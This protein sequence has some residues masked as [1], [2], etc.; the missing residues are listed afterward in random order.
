MN[1]KYTIEKVS[2]QHKII[3]IRYNKPDGSEPYWKNFN[4]E[5][6]SA[7]NQ[8]QIDQMAKA[9]APVVLRAWDYIDTT[10]EVNPADIDI[11]V[12]K[13][14]VYT[15]PPPEPP[16]SMDQQKAAA[17]D[18]VIADRTAREGIGTSN[19]WIDDGSGGKKQILLDTLPADQHKVTMSEAASQGNVGGPAG[20]DLLRVHEYGGDSGNEKVPLYL[21]LTAQRRREVM[22]VLR[23]FNDRCD[24]AEKA[25]MDKIEAGDFSS[26]FDAEFQ[27][28]VEAEIPP[29]PL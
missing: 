15:E 2:R 16:P 12:E 11:G 28:L 10:P 21:E 17:R 18:A 24:R 13:D 8:T 1:Y 22:E 23:D 19:Y 4:P 7:Y 20:N 26:S 5:N 14:A 9:F 3:R 27:L 25:V 6:P 29:P